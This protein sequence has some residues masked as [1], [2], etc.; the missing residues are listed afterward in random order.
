MPILLGVLLAAVAL[1]AP[2]QTQSAP[3][4]ER[5]T[6]RVVTAGLA[7]PWEVAWGPDD[8]LW[9]TERIARQVTRVD[10]ANGARSVA[11][12]IDEVRQLEPQDGLLGLALHPA[13]LRGRDMDYV[14]VAYTY[15]ADPGPADARR[16]KVRRYTY[17]AA[18][19][20]LG[21]PLDVLTN[22]PAGSDHVAGRLAFGPD[23]KLYL[24]VGDQGNN[25]FGLYCLPIRAQ[26]LPTA[27]EVAAG[28]FE[29]Y[30]G[31]I[32]RINLDG[33]VPA[34]NPTF[35]GVRSH[36]FTTGHR[37]PQGLTF[38]P[39]GNLYSSEHGPSMDDE[40]NRIVA[41]RN[42]GWPHVAGYQDDRVY[43]DAD[44]SKSSPEPC[45]SL[46][47]DA[48]VAPRSVPQQNESAWRDAAFMPPIQTFFTVD[49]DFDF[50]K[51][52]AT[53]APSGIDVYARTSGGIPGWSNSV[54]VTSLMRGIVYRVR[55]NAEGT[56]R[57]G[58]PLEYF[59]SNAR[60]RDVAISPDGL[61]I[62]VAA[63]RGSK[64]H[65]DSILAFTYTGR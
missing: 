35:A 48:I 41:G 26:E 12:M 43:V 1:T 17:D 22:L 28:N 52:N 16:V 64:D 63:D 34:D 56:A 31:K 10:P 33:S 49:K 8:R 6:M 42:Y 60:F 27:A 46:K 44:W 29:H 47:W 58:V 36:I 30:Q 39:D 5:F 37:N 38:A 15:D 61:T 13:L 57:T 7:G 40:L 24:S 50:S 54:L 53:I 25:Q 11:L 62:Y 45:A 51:A 20:R 65:A 32:L 21:A 23:Q 59:K 9:I 19:E 18:T 2:Q 4:P 14:Y 3:G 55:L